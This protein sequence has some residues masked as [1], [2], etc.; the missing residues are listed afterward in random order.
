MKLEK[1]SSSIAL[2]FSW[3][4][5]V[6][7]IQYK[8]IIRLYWFVFQLAEI[9]R[10]DKKSYVATVQLLNDRDKLLDIGFD[11]ICEYTGNIDLE[12]DF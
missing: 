9:L 12:M 7:T 4:N 10:K 5:I 3:Q 2:H 1:S 11:N 6:C 8:K